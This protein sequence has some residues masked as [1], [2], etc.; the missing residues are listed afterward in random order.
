MFYV[1]QEVDLDVDSISQA[2]DIYSSAPLFKPH[3]RHIDGP[4]APYVT[5]LVA[6][7]VAPLPQTTLLIAPH[8]SLL[9]T[10]HL[11]PQTDRFD[12]MDLHGMSVSLTGLRD[13]LGTSHPPGNCTTLFAM[14]TPLGATL[15]LGGR[16][17]HDVPRVKA[18]LANVLDLKTAVQ[19]ETCLRMFQSIEGKLDCFGRWIEQRIFARQWE[20]N[21]AKR[22]AQIAM[23]ILREPHA[24]IDSFARAQQVSSRQ[25][26]RD[27]L[28]WFALS[29]K[30]FAQTARLQQAA[31]LAASGMSLAQVAAEAHYA[32]Q[33]HMSR[34]VQ[35]LTG[36]SPTRL[37]APR[38]HP[39][40]RAFAQATRGGIVYM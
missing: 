27:F 30:R 25:L 18:P 34:A 37:F 35:K 13:A 20:G 38:I 7:E 40:A 29:P 6:M 12:S 19:L 16:T 11:G 24:S 3:I 17:L 15:L 10:V 32:D 28:R 9:L 31:R 36:L 26:E 21:A 2:G 14:L 8:E 39:M 22:T 1:Q 33:A 5:A 23:T 4:L